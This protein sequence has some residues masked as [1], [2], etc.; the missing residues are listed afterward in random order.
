MRPIRWLHISDI[1]LRI[2]NEWSQDIVLNAM[3]AHIEKQRSQGVEAD[4]I[5][6][7][8]DIAFSGKSEEYVLAENFFEA[9]QTASGVPIER[10]FC[11]PGN[12]DIDRDRHNL[13]FRGAQRELDGQGQVDALLEGGE[14]LETLLKR[15]ENYRHFQRAYFAGQD[16]TET[17]DGLGYVSRL[18]IEELQLAIV[19]LD[20]AWLAEGGENDH[21]KLLI[22]ERQA[23]NAIELARGGNPPPNIIVGMAHHP[24]HLLQHFDR[25]PV[26]NRAEQGFHFFHCGH[27]HE[28]EAHITGP[29]ASG[30]LTL[31][32]GAS[33]QTRQTH[34]AYYT[35]K[36][37]LLHGI[38]NATS[39]QYNPTRSTFSPTSPDEY[40][41]E[42]TP[43]TTCG[44]GELA[45]AMRTYC[46]KLRPLVHYLSA[47]ALSQKAEFP[48]ASQNRYTFGSLHLLRTLSDNDLK[49]ATIEFMTFT[50]ILHVLYNRKSLSEILEHY[51][52]SIRK[53]G[54]VLM[55]ACENDSA[56]RERIENYDE[57]CR[58]L[59]DNEPQEAFSHT[60]QLLDELAADKAWS[61]LREQA[62]RLLDVDD[63]TVVTQAERMLALALANSGELAD[64]EK[65]IKHYRSLAESEMVDF[66]DLGNLAGLLMDSGCMN[67]AVDVIV[68]GIKMF[69]QKK[70]YFSEI[71]HAIVAMSGNKELR[72][73]IEDA[74]RGQT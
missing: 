63:L 17:A 20:S 11:V 56:L 1:H 59:A 29:G 53:Y 39:V 28:P 71:G 62:E 55:V 16:R 57:D 13:C 65:A 47:L 2:Q 46:P 66:T 22:G 67:E 12:H 61:M 38:R 37:D 14:D 52:Y 35:V 68:D 54:K 41:I 73:Q 30:C 18:A 6:V 31:V 72:L 19:G 21:G 8:G 42:V 48:I 33:F 50:N 10:I 5:L 15:Q 36:L 60:L 32:A 44:V 49:Q 40:P 25:Q 24:L 51:G 4:F 34:N 45:S 27:L 7:T 74:T 3:C 69:P 23:I 43:V 64:R 9:I 58:F 70:Q 26:R